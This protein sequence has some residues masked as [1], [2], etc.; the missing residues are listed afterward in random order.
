MGWINSGK[1]EN[2]LEGPSE[3]LNILDVPIFFYTITFA[4]S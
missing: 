4:A 3:S 1:L 2:M